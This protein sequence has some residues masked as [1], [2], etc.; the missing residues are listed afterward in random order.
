MY[1]RVITTDFEQMSR[2][3]R[4][5]REPIIDKLNLQ[6]L[7]LNSRTSTQPHSKPDPKILTPSSNK[8]ST[9]EINYTIVVFRY[10]NIRRDLLHHNR[11]II[12]FECYFDNFDSV[13]LLLKR[14]H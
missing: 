1:V 10:K 2:P 8:H 11:L 14:T 5:K 7:E 3:R 13:G 6:V 4:V 9:L 12:N